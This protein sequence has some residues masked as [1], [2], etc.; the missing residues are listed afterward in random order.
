MAITTQDGLISALGT[1]Q[2]L[3]C[4]KQSITTVAGGFY[5]LWRAAGNP[6]VGVNP[7][8]AAGVVP[9]DATVGAIPF[10]NPTG[11]NTSYLGR[12]SNAQATAG[13]LFVYDRL[14]HS[15]SLNGTLTTAQTIGTPALTRSTSGDGVELWLEWT[16][17]TGAT[18]SN[19]TCSYTNEA[20]TAGRTTVSTALIASAPA[21]R[22]Q[23]LPLQAGDR[24]VRAVASLTLSV[25]TGTAGNFGIVL[26]KRLAEIAIPAASFAAV[27]DALLGGMP[28]VEDDACLSFVLLA[29]TTSSGIILPRLDIIQ[30]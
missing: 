13:T 18:A 9:T 16:T 17:A 1:A 19:V 3:S 4:Q 2:R 11:G 10:T 8:S 25:S 30:G 21:N 27:Q 24:G 26:M 7:G 23:P 6:G 22:M 5:S 12:A 29:T 15:D 28:V 20:G 14:V